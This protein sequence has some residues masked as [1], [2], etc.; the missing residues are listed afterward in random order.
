M[1]PPPIFS[2]GG[3]GH[4]GPV[5]PKERPQAFKTAWMKLLRYFRRYRLQISAIVAM[6]MIGTM[7]T[8]IGPNMLSKMT[9]LIEEGVTTGN[10][11]LDA[12]TRIGMLLVILYAASGILNF[13]QGF[14]LAK[15]AQ[16]TGRNLRDDISRKINRLPLRFFDTSVQ[17]DLQS[18][19]TNDADTVGQS[20]NQC[21]QSLITAATLLVGSI[22]MMSLT[23]MEMMVT[24]VVS[25]LSGFVLVFFILRRSHKFFVQQQQNLG[26]MNGHIEETYSNH[27]IVHAYNGQEI[28]KRNFDE[29][30][31]RLFKSSFRSQFMGSL[32]PPLMEFLSNFGYLMVCVVGAVLVVDGKISIGIIVAFMLYVRLF[33]QPLNQL[34]RVL[35][36]MQSVAAAAERVFQF[37]EEPEMDDE[38]DKTYLTKPVRG[39]VEFRDVCFGYVPGKEII[40]GFSAKV[41]A[42]QKVAIVGPTGAGKTTLVNLLMR[43]YEV[44][45]GDILIDGTSIKEMRRSELRDRF[46]MVLQDTWIFEGTIRENIIYSKEGVT[47]EQVIEACRAVGL[48]HFIQT[49]PDGL[50][51]MLSERANISMGQRQQITIARAIIE[52]AP[53]LILDE[54]TSSVDTRTEVIIQE[55]MD[56]LTDRRTSFVIAHRL[57]TVRNAD[58]IL[59][60]R[61]GSII[62]QGNHEQLLSRNGFYYDLYNSQFEDAD[63]F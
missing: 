33:T 22:I 25:S 15:V 30:N 14:I 51:T 28:A 53:M 13:L 49:L 55:A 57:S 54:A 29:I 4:R 44:D 60:V 23:N 43:F 47:E 48:Y 2:I 17:G 32:T 10:M 1:S 34:S 56:S 38:S 8:L 52:D 37:L 19:V 61:D 42:G 59:V 40:H 9:D 50:D 31:D 21:I 24:A 39:D 27:L 46:C 12:V 62:E 41:K 16:M 36:E 20:M 3:P 63:L 6:G 18:R 35:V 58:L 11:D 5:V 26:E 7:L 45:S